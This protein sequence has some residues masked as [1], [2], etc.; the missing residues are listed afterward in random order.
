M[1]ETPTAPTPL[2]IE[3]LDKTVHDR[4]DFDCGEPSLN[5]YLEFTARQHM[6][7]GY[8][9]VWVAVSRKSSGYVRENC[10]VCHWASDPVGRD[11]HLP[12]HLHCV[13]S[14]EQPCPEQAH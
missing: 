6:D 2:V 7:K 9:Q 11:K 10:F 5:E 13:V 4:R 3:H 12:A 8:A 14:C 1:V